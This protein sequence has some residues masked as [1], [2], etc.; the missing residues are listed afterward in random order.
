MSEVAAGAHDASPTPTP[1][2]KSE[3]LPETRRHARSRRHQ[4]PDKN[5]GGENSFARAF[6]GKASERNA[7]KRVK[8]SKSRA[9]RAE[10]GIAQTEFLANRLA[11]RA[12][13]LPVKKIHRVDGK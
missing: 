12:Q 1:R 9:E 11:D 2:R 3:N 5:A 13:N 6:I 8:Q 10:R 7:D 4:T